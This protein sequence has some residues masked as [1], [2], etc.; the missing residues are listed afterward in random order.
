MKFRCPYCKTIIGPE[1]QSKCPQCGKA[2]KIPAKLQ[3][4]STRERKRVKQRIIRDGEHK[5]QAMAFNT[6]DNS[7]RRPAVTLTLLMIMAVIGALLIGRSNK[8]KSGKRNPVTR[9]T[10][11]L[12]ALYIASDRFYYDTLRYPTEAE[13]LKALVI[14]PGLRSWRGPYVNIVKPDP[15]RNKYIY[16]IVS[17]NNFT[18]FSSGPDGIGGNGDDIY[19]YEKEE[20]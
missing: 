3:Q 16:K 15:W 5:K 1:L 19:P 11:E 7:L 14:N 13:N 4:T 2:M 12:R 8:P 10:L 9:A 6:S 17:N 18:V 20:P